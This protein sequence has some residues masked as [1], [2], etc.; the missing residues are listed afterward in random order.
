MKLAT[1]CSMILSMSM[2]APSFA[3]DYYLQSDLGVHGL[4]HLCKYS[5]G[6]VY[7]FNAIEL[8]PLSVSDDVSGPAPP[9][10]ARKMGFKAGEYQD[11]MTK[12]CVYDVLGQKAAIRVGA[13]ELCPLT[14]E[15]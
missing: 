5:N 12:V 15:F 11:G 14:H 2:S 10:S 6:R 7:S 13:V 8:C 4:Y 9:T 1:F 3:F